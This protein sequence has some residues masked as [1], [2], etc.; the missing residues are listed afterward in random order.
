MTTRKGPHGHLVKQ[1]LMGIDWEFATWRIIPGL[2]S[3]YIIT[4]V[5]KS[6]KYRVV[7]PLQAFFVGDILNLPCGFLRVL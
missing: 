4:M 3:G 1:R 5:S 2:V 6:R 7:G